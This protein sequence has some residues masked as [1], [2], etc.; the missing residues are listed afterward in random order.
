MKS[1]A[2]EE[3]YQIQVPKRG[4]AK[5]TCLGIGAAIDAIVIIVA[6]ASGNSEPKPS[7]DTSVMC[8]CPFVYSYDGE[9]FI[10]DSEAFGGSIFEAA[11]RTDWGKLNKLR[12]VEGICRVKITD[13]LQETDYID[14]VKLLVVDHSREVEVLPSF[15]GN[16]HILSKPYA[17]LKAIDFQGNEVLE[18]VK[19]KDENFWLSNPFG[20]DPGI[21]SQVRDGLI[22]KFPRPSNTAFVKLAFNLKNTL[23]AAHM[24]AK[25][26]E[27]HGRDL[28]GWYELMNSSVKARQAF[29]RAVIREGMLLIK[30]WNGENWQTAG[31]VWEVGANV[32]RDQLVRLDIQGIPGEVLQVKLE[33]TA[34]FWMINSVQVDYTPDLPLD[35]T[36]LS[37]SEA[38]DHLGTDLQQILQATDNR[39]YEMST[40]DWA[41]LIF[42]VP[43]PKKEYQRSFI[44]KTSGYYTINV[45]AEGVPQTELVNRFITEPAA[46]GQYTLQLLNGYV[47]SALAQLR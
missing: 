36:E 35:V 31:F 43:P 40:G 34:G 32:F 3:V 8:G 22:L 2:M 16:L 45:T 6:L 33:S 26:L 47:T 29:Q 13:E 30:L 39:Y 4:N 9:E 41:E 28:A 15:S 38:K 27:L 25:F 20:R 5:W 7:A 17:P 10:L 21:K 18:M 1:I 44:L 11:K 12:K 42:R 14:E 46:F 37:I 24:Q 23:W 19:A